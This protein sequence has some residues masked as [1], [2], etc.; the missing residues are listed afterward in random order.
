MHCAFILGGWDESEGACIYQVGIGGASTKQK[1]AMSGSGSFLLHG[2]VDS[3]YKDNMTKQQAE[4]F[5]VK[6]NNIFLIL[7]LT[8]AMYKDTVCGGIIRLVNIDKNGA[9]R[10][11]LSPN[12]FKYP[13]EDN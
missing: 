1:F 6:G 10:S 5:I 7:G 3:N 12:D 13:N 11:F 8:L 9:T 2:Y 4:E